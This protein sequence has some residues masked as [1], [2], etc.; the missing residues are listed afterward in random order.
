M[1]CEETLLRMKEYPESFLCLAAL[2]FSRK[3]YDKYFV[4]IVEYTLSSVQTAMHNIIKELR[5]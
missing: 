1:K 4:I 5:T 3:S 2:R